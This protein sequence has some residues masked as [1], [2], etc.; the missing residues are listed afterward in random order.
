MVMITFSGSG[1]AVK[2]ASGIER[3]SGGTLI[4]VLGLVWVMCILFG[5]IGV[6][7][8]AYFM[9]AAFAANV[10]LNAGLSLE[11]AHFFL[12]FPTVFAVVT[13]PVALA[14]VVAS[15]MA[16]G[17]YFKTSMETIKAAFA[18][19]FLPFLVAYAPSLILEIGP[20]SSVFYIELG[21]SLLFILSGQFALIG[22]F[23]TDMKIIERILLG[24]IAV[25][26]IFYLSSRLVAVVILILV[27]FAVF[28]IMHI[29]RYRSEKKNNSALKTK[30][31]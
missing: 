17:N 10:L 29:L 6:T 12:M 2:L 20:E 28:L 3:F 11:A 22:Y 16:N 31:S 5:M 18:G 4:G 15:K 24:V 9:G 23:I 26:C 19:F 21:M 8:V 27:L 30:M 7:S 25:S 1:L 14:C 13:P